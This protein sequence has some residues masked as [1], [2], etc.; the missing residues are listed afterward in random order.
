MTIFEQ[1]KKLLND[2]LE[3]NYYSFF[4]KGEKSLSLTFFYNIKY[5][6][7]KYIPNFKTPNT[8]QEQVKENFIHVL[9]W[10]SKNNF[11]CNIKIEDE[12]WLYDIDFFTF[13]FNTLL[14][15]LKNK[16]LILPYIIIKTK[17]NPVLKNIDIF[18]D[19]IT[20]FQELNSNL[21]FSLET[22]LI[23]INNIDYILTPK[24]LNFIINNK[25]KLKININPNNF[26]YFDQ[27]IFNLLDKLPNNLYLYEEANY[28]WTPDHKNKEYFTFLTKYLNYYYNIYKDNLL[29]ALIENKLSLFS[30]KDK[31]ILDGTG[32][33]MGQCSF[34]QSLCILLEDLTLNLCPK[35]QFDDQIIGK[36]ILE[37]DTLI[38]EPQLIELI[39]MKVHLK[40]HSTSH[41]ENC[42]LLPFC[43]GCCCKSSYDICLNPI[44]PVRQFCEMQ[45]QKFGFL[46][47]NLYKNN[48][49]SK[50]KINNLNISEIY[51]KYLYAFIPQEDSND[52]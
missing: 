30:L 4:K 52:S 40:R 31:G 51:K 28:G 35:F 9:N 48:L 36:M 46:F 2:I 32:D 11:C 15:R 39:S 10:Y 3:R 45:I 42:I 13:I 27:V 21:I 17:L 22:N 33:C 43:N 1:N 44:I 16:T 41:C 14:E 19:Y 23:D 25:I 18:Q 7:S 24:V 20:Q 34:Y 5:N 49:I 26:A 12:F 37:N 6:N 47:N 8:N 38:A 29:D 50:E